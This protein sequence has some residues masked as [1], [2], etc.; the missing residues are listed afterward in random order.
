[1]TDEQTGNF[2]GYIGVKDGEPLFR[3]VN[4]NSG[5]DSLR[6]SIFKNPEDALSRYFNVRRVC[7]FVYPEPVRHPEDWGAIDG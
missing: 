5:N 7:V 4:D 6:L 1:M 2:I 3:K